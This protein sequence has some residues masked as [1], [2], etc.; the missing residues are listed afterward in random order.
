[1]QIIS[2]VE[3]I[4]QRF[5]SAGIDNAKRVAVELIAHVLDCKPLEIYLRTDPLPPEDLQILEKLAGRIDA[6][7]PLQY[8]VGH[9]D[10]RGLEIK[11]DPRALIPRPETELLVEEVLNSKDWNNLVDV[12][13]GTGC[14]VLALAKERP[15]A[16]FTAIDLLPASLEL[17]R[18]NA[19]FHGLEEKI[20][21]RENHLLNG[22]APGSC[23]AVV[24][25]LPYI[26]TNDWKELSPAVRDHEPQSALDS[27]PT[28][29]EL[30][31]EL[32]AQARTILV[33]GG[34]LFLEFGFDQGE[35]IFRCL[36]K[37]GYLNI[38]IK[39]DLAGLDRIATTEN[40]RC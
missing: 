27:G 10:F 12:G 9:V 39:Q 34:M 5:S 28:G 25:N 23:N 30:I 8:V 26:A 19:R 24:A 29:M 35:A 1:M 11:C 31:E 16:D 7:E 4:E 40:P 13:T 37:L 6:G 20:Q 32:A 22:F 14:I 33:P 15:D 21:W 3:S 36:E 38:Q 2:L 17:A 18:E